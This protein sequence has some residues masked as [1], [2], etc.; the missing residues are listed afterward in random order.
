MAPSRVLAGRIV[1]VVTPVQGLARLENRAPPVEA[2]D[3]VAVAARKIIG[4]YLSQLRANDPGTRVG[5]DPEALHDMRVATRRLRAAVRALGPGI[6]A[7]SRANLEVELKWLGQLLGSVRDLDVQ[8]ERVAHYSA[9]VPRGHRDGLRSF[10]MYLQRER[11]R[12]RADML[13]ALSSPRY[14]RLLIR[15]ERFAASGAPR[16]TSN[17]GAREPLAG[18]GRRTLQD[19]FRRLL[20]RGRAL[21]GLPSPE[22]LHALRMRAKRLR[23]VLEFLRALTGKPGRR[24]IKRLVRLQDVLGTYHDRIVTA[25]RVR[26][27][28][29][30]PGGQ[31]P[32]ATLLTLSAFDAHELQNADEQR[33]RLRATWK[34]F[35][36][37]RTR[38]DL[39]AVVRDL[40]KMKEH[41][42]T[43]SNLQSA[44]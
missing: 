10:R 25:D 16:G 2:D 6:P 13:V 43:R 41:R 19:A 29:Q 22:D 36:R 39:R 35:V 38:A 20:K 7:R 44:S 27:Y 8:L 9:G 32:P 23:Y 24:L 5:I 31:Q 11:A 34:Q 33:A 18:V 40:Q 1:T 12:H 26:A 14:A 37:K 28:V 30:G 15:M 3:T 21:D 4:S 42:I 17:R